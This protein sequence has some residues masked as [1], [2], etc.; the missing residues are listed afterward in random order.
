MNLNIDLSMWQLVLLIID[1]GI[2]IIAIGVVPEG[3]RPSSS[4]AWLLAILVLPIV[5]LPLFLLMGSPYINRRRHR[6][7]Q[8]ANE[9]I[10]DV[11]AST[12]NHPEGRLSPEVESLIQL[13]RNLTGHPALIGHNMGLHASYNEA[14]LAMARAVDRAEKYVL[15]E[16][17]I[18]SWD[19]VTDVFFQSLK[20][21]RERGVEVKLLLDQ[22]GSYKYKGYRTLG[23]RL[24]AIDVDW[25]L[26]LPLQLHK[27]RFRRP[28]LRNHRKI[29]VIDGN[30]GF[31]GSMNM[32]KR[33]YKTK[34]RAWIDYM[35]ELTGPVVTSL[36]A[37]FAVDWYLESEEQLS[38]DMQPY[39]DA[40]TADANHL[41]L[42]PSG[43]GYTTEPNLRMFNSVVHHAKETLV[44]C[45][46]YFIPDESLLE[47]V[48]TACYRDV[49]VHLL[50][51]AKAD[52][53]MVNHAQS[54]YYQALLEAG[55]RIFQFP[56]PF[57]L[58][59]KFILADPNLPNRDPLCMFGSSN[60]DMR[61]FGLNYESTMLVAKGNLIE[62]F[63]Q[64]ALNYKQVCH[65]LTLEEWNER[66]LLRR[67]VDNVMRLTSAL[68]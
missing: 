24:T 64:L 30:T 23:K 37:V 27:G 22:I 57:V 25:R 42:V 36:A 48:T 56:E 31:L 60:M 12:P 4:T 10:S 40:V 16:I 67:Y 68:Q 2:K 52:Q 14:I 43:P 3:R 51:S 29:V 21:A 6:I 61:S 26:M 8:E 11:T 20:R 47:A 18:Q 63:T 53:F 28:D 15:I 7:Q 54:S 5:G 32:I 13:N 33:Q 65:E 49:E 66:G 1:Y 58:H 34:Y 55:V 19:E 62:D 17:Y 45:S 41:Q 44:M 35:V 38:L 59:S 46:P 9:L 39:D 50:V